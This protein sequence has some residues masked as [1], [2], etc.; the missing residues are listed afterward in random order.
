MPAQYGTCMKMLEMI[1]HLL[2]LLAMKEQ[3][4][5]Q[6]AYIREQAIQ[7]KITDFLLK[8]VLRLTS[9]LYTP[10]QLINYLYIL[11][12]QKHKRAALWPPTRIIF[13]CK[14]VRC[15]CVKRKSLLP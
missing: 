5:Q 9:M 14:E 7:E 2:P 1:I 15:Q 3:L 13:L 8:T 12:C 11:N 10:I 4:Q 6:K